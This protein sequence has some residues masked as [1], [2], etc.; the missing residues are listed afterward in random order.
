MDAQCH[1][2]SIQNQSLPAA[3]HVPTRM[4]PECTDDTTQHCLT[5][6]MPSHA[7]CSF[8]L[9]CEVITN[10]QRKYLKTLGATAITPDLFLQLSP[11]TWPHFPQWERKFRE[12]FPNHCKSALDLQLLASMPL[13]LKGRGSLRHPTSLQLSLLPGNLCIYSSRGKSQ[14]DS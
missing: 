2:Q 1:L 12:Q 6:S 10:P 13:P 9:I 8:E 4:G 5:P 7:L 3:A 14:K 11:D